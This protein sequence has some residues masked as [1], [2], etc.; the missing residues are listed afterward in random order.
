M[1]SYRPVD[2]FDDQPDASCPELAELAPRGRAPDGRQPACEWRHVAEGP[3]HARFPRRTLY[4]VSSP[5]AG[6]MLRIHPRCWAGFLRGGDF[7]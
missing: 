3:A 4:D 5:G 7:G 2:L 6:E 1:R